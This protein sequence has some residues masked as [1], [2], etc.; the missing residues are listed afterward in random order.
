MWVM[1]KDPMEEAPMRIEDA[2]R[3]KSLVEQMQMSIQAT[4]WV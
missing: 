3:L 2:V 4:T 1:L